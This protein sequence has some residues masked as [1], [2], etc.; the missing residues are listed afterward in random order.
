MLRKYYEDI[1]RG[2]KIEAKLENIISEV[3]EIVNT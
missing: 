3:M 1:E 2:K